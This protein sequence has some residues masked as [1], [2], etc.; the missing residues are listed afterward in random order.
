MVVPVVQLLPRHR[1]KATVQD[2]LALEKM[3]LEHF[4]GATR[5]P[6]L[7]GY[8]LRNPWGRPRPPE[9][10]EHMPLMVYA[11][12][13]PASDDYFR[14]LQR[15]LQDALDEGLILVERLEATLL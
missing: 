4:G 1:V 8:G 13:L 14:A 9:L 11:A 7:S 2:L 3:L 12:P 6:R 10:N 5:L 15:E